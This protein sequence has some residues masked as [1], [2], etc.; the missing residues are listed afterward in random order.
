MDLSRFGA[1]V[2]LLKM[3][4]NGKGVMKKIVVIGG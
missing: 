1:G 3:R 4:V 2:Y